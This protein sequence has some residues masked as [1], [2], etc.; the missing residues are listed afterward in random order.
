MISLRIG[1]VIQLT[2]CILIGMEKNGYGRILNVGSMG[3]FIPS[4]T[5]AVY[6]ATKAYIMFFSDVLCGECK[7][8]RIRVNTLCPRATWTEFA[9]KANTENTLFF[10]FAV[11]K[12][13]KVVEIAYPLN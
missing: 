7:K 1:F 6:S 3:S 8:M 11:M 4:P 12:S 13:E 10:K 9:S 5:D 2:K